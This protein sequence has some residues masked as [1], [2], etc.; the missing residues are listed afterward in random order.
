MQTT[1]ETS[2]SIDDLSIAWKQFRLYLEYTYKV[3]VAASF[4]RKNGKIYCR[5]YADMVYRDNRGI[6]PRIYTDRFKTSSPQWIPEFEHL[7]QE[8]EDDQDVLDLGN[9]CD[10]RL[11]KEVLKRS[12]RKYLPK[13]AII[14]ARK[15]RKENKKAQK[16]LAC[17]K[18]A[19]QQNAN[20]KD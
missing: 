4:V 3:S 20:H 8:L 9:T 11:R 18:K 13:L 16:A 19:A 15:Q 17:K 2:L 10:H 6:E 12:I 1:I 5:L 14:D 7:V